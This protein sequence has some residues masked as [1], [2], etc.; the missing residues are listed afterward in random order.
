M[1]HEKKSIPDQVESAGKAPQQE[2]PG[3]PLWMR[4]VSRRAGQLLLFVIAIV[5]INGIRSS[6]NQRPSLSRLPPPPSITPPGRLNLQPLDP[7]MF[8]KLRQHRATAEYWKVA[9][10]DLHRYRFFLPEDPNEPAGRYFQRVIGLY[11]AKAQAA[12]SK[13][14][15]NV[16]EDLIAMVKRH[17]AQ[18]EYTLSV[19]E[20]TQK[21]AGEQGLLND[22]TTTGEQMA[23]GEQIINA[24]FDDP[25]L[26]NEIEDSEARALM[27]SMLEVQVMQMEQFREIE[28]MQA[29]LEERHPLTSFALPVSPE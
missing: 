22:A 12:R 20:K 10:A 26:V 2:S 3:I 18:D 21:Y 16:D 8:Q 14:I 23:Q 27:E 1:S 11:R 13:S 9:V 17:L 4:R 29:R 5:V 25:N 15:E 19:L 24:L 7:E 6:R 28:I